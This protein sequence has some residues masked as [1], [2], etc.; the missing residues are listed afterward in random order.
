MSTTLPD[1]DKITCCNSSNVEN[2]LPNNL[3]QPHKIEYI[4]MLENILHN[5]V[6]L[7][8]KLLS[9]CA[10]FLNKLKE[11]KPGTIRKIATTMSVRAGISTRL[12]LLLE[13]L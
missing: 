10:V 5:I 1:P 2:P 12:S 9:I 13:Y 3:D 6:S 7:S 4:I 8:E 11:T